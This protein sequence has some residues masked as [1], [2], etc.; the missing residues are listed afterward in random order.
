M[1]RPAR[2]YKAFS[3]VME[4]FLWCMSGVGDGFFLDA[5]RR[6]QVHRV[7]QNRSLPLVRFP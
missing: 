1:I 3:N 2:K 6:T 5:T 7:A 4:I